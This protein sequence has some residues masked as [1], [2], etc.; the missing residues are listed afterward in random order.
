MRPAVVKTTG[1]CP[2]FCLG[3]Q[4]FGAPGSSAP[5]VLQLG[6]VRIRREPSKKCALNQDA[7]M[8]PFWAFGGGGG[9][10]VGWSAG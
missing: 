5:P 2:S 3:R 7:L 4:E 8:V 1:T 6:L 10:R 9:W